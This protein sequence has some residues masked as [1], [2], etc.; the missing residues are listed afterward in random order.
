MAQNFGRDKRR[1]EEAKKKKRE[2][3]RNKRL[4]KN[5][6][7]TETSGETTPPQVLI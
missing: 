5:P 1:I 3:K 7:P 2:E 4:N 6:N